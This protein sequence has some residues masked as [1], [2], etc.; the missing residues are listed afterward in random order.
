MPAKYRA[1]PVVI[2]GH[3]FPS[4]KE[5]KRY[6]ELKLLEQ[7]GKI[8]DLKLQPPFDLHVNGVKVC[9]YKGDFSY[10]ENG[11]RVIEDVKGVKTPMYRLKR[12]MMRAEYGIEIRET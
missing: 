7:A 12:K 4:K 5:G 2:D 1:I 3:R 9:F 8:S 6:G 11:V 10:V